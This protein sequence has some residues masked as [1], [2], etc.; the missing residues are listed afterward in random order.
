MAVIDFEWIPEQIFRVNKD[1]NPAHGR[2][3][4]LKK[5]ASDAQV[6]EF[7]REI[8]LPL[9]N[10]AIQK[11]PKALEYLPGQIN[12]TVGFTKVKA[13]V[14]FEGRYAEDSMNVT[15]PIGVSEEEVLRLP[16]VISYHQRVIEKIEKKEAKKRA[17][18][19]KAK[20]KKAKKEKHK[21]EDLAKLLQG[22]TFKEVRSPQRVVFVNQQGEEVLLSSA[23]SVWDYGD[24][25]EDWLYAKLGSNL[26]N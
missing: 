12:L 18:A 9:F 25:S 26:C 3:Y 15:V 10:E 24:A 20:K 21:M 23:H 22:C 7:I 11:Y 14:L 13:L 8:G 1:G 6:S 2:Y 17:K 16:E 4:W 19:K 5:E